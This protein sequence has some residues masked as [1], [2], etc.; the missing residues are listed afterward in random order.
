MIYQALCRHCRKKLNPQTAKSYGGDNGIKKK[1]YGLSFL[2]C[3]LFP[4][5]FL[6]PSPQSFSL[7]SPYLISFFPFISLFSLVTYLS[8]PPLSFT[9]PHPTFIS[10]FSL[11]FSQPLLLLSGFFF[12]SDFLQ[13]ENDMP[14]CSF[15]G[16][17]P[18]GC[19]LNFWIC[20]LVSE[21]NLGGILSHISSILFFFLLLVNPLCV[22]Y[23][24]RSCPTVFEYSDM[25]YLQSLFSLCFGFQGF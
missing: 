4:R 20:D 19:S 12:I 8:C 15:F 25:F 9:L 7:P 17:Y 18:A 6:T 16:I 24:F 22:C 10:P 2:L 1:L 3:L 23:T 13:F 11:Q 5:T 21:I 14:R